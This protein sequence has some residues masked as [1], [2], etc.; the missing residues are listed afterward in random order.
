MEELAEQTTDSPTFWTF[1]R[2]DSNLQ[3]N[4][5]DFQQFVRNQHT[6]ERFGLTVCQYLS[7]IKEI[8]DGFN[9]QDGIGGTM[10]ALLG[11][12]AFGLFSNLFT[13]VILFHATNLKRPRNYLI[14]LH[15]LTDVF[16]CCCTTPITLLITFHL[17]WYFDNFS[18][19]LA[20]F[21]KAA[22]F[23]ASYVTLSV[24]A[25]HQFISYRFK[26]D[27]H[28]FNLTFVVASL[29]AVPYV[30]V[31]TTEVVD[32]FEPWNEAVHLDKALLQCN[33]TKPV[34]CSES[35]W[36]RLPF[37]QET[38]IIWTLVLLYVLPIGG[39]LLSSRACEQMKRDPALLPRYC[40]TPMKNRE[41]FL[42]LCF[43]VS[44]T[45]IHWLPMTAFTFLHLFD[46]VEFTYNRYLIC[47][48]IGVSTSVIKPLIYGLTNRDLRSMYADT[49][50]S[51]FCPC[52][53][54]ARPQRNHLRRLIRLGMGISLPETTRTQEE[55][56]F[57]ERVARYKQHKHRFRTM[58]VTTASLVDRRLVHQSSDPLRRGH[59]HS[60]R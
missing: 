21:L 11:V 52:G 41:N 44:I 22:S 46:W 60:L 48:T 29:F 51:I 40:G 50:R 12:S 38:Y 23:F 49:V 37:S 8:Q 31:V 14:I 16:A 56:E 19:K 15:M 33:M 28:W 59:H 13:L 39:L 6:L 42:M 5:F 55:R 35:G 34:I 2:N 57:L 9:Y 24:L 45:L 26:F 58:T 32:Y 36:H 20:S 1:F 53:L 30:L 27:S 54:C 18:C 43:L 7:K 3:L 47:Q 17:F 10:A 4:F 25:A